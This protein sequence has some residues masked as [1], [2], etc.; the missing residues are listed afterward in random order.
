MERLPGRAGVY[1]APVAEGEALARRVHG[2]WLVV[3]NG[4]DARQ[5]E[6]VLSRLRAIVRL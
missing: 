4:R 2:G 1:R 6:Y 3:A 5:R